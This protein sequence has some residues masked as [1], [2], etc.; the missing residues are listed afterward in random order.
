MKITQLSVFTEN[1]PGHVVAP[2]R[3]LA[4]A[5]INIR[6]MSLPDTHP[7]GIMRLIV[8]DWRKAAKLLEE[9]SF[10]VKSTEVV[11]V[12]IPDR[13]GAV[14]E[15]LHVLERTSISIEYMYAFPFGHERDAILIFGFADPGT[16]VERLQTAG[17]KV[18]GQEA[19]RD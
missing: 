14:Y 9:A 18:V 17:V 1:K 12:Q 19:L 10:V 7:F 13:P 5:N 2:C 16:A 8:A 4:N 11:A 15:V 3:V 6:A